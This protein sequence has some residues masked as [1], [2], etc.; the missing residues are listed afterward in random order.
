MIVFDKFQQPR[1]VFFELLLQAR[2]V[3]SFAKVLSHNNNV[4]GS[5]VAPWFPSSV[6][7]LL[8]EARFP[9]EQDTNQLKNDVLKVLWRLGSRVRYRARA[10]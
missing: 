10:M 5:R 3:S 6:A 2:A 9:R 1:A 8:T 4:P 7:L